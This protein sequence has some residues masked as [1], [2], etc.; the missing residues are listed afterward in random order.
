MALAQL[1]C[2]SL[3]MVCSGRSRAECQNLA[4]YFVPIDSGPALV[5][6]WNY[7]GKEVVR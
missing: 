5:L 4:S 7:T 3:R 6:V 1:A 2:F